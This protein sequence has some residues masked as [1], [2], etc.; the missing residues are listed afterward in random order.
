[1]EHFNTRYNYFVFGLR[2]LFLL[3]FTGLLLAFVFKVIPFLLTDKLN[4][5]KIICGIPA[6]LFILSFFVYRFAKLL[7]TE[8]MNIFLGS[9]Q[10]ILKDAL[11]SA[12]N[13]FDK[14]DIK[15][16]SSSIY[17]TKIWNFKTIILYF[18]DETKME[19]PQFLYWN[20]KEI[21]SAL[22]SNNITY[23]GEEPYRWKWFDTRYYLFDKNSS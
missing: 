8:R 5:V 11:T 7:L 21:K 10:M 20:F 12:I 6:G 23:L 16:F 3:F 18:T 9:G 14:K 15:G 1:M 4:W 2:L 17:Q 22:E 13:D 19:F